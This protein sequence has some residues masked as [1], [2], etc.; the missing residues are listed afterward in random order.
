MRCVTPVSRDPSCFVDKLSPT[1]AGRVRKEVLLRRPE[2]G[3]RSS[4]PETSVGAK[5]HW[6][7]AMLNVGPRARGSSQ[8]RPR[9]A[10]VA[11]G[12]LVYLNICSVSL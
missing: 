1:A 5:G 4:P 9:Q 3:R 11:L 10:T 8:D 12:F 6:N 7:G 2:C